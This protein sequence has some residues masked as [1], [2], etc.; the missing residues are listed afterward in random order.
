[1]EMCAKFPSRPTRRTS[2]GGGPTGSRRKRGRRRDPRGGEPDARERSSVGV[3][4]GHEPV[5]EAQGGLLAASRR[6]RVGDAQRTGRHTSGGRV[7]SVRGPDEVVDVEDPGAGAG[8]G[9]QRGRQVARV[10][11]EHG[12]RV[13]LEPICVR[14]EGAA[15]V[16]AGLPKRR[17]EEAS[18]DRDRTSRRLRRDL[19]DHRRQGGLI[20]RAAPRVGGR[21]EAVNLR[22]PE[23]RGRVDRRGEAQGATVAAAREERKKV[24]EPHRT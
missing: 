4:R 24:D 14:A 23:G 21:V 18:L 3:A 11:E 15:R 22:L 2:P 10:Q 20:Q 6:R 5:R 19:L 1:M 9:R 16:P 17:G 7:V 12:G 13:E 8:E